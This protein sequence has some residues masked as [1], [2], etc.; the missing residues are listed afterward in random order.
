[1]TLGLILACLYVIFSR[2][3]SRWRTAERMVTVFVGV[4]IAFIILISIF[5]RF[6]DTLLLV[7]A[8]SALTAAIVAG[9]RHAKAFPRRRLEL[10]L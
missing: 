9:F 8:V 7:A 1:M 5:P 2:T 6:E 3:G 10:W 4:L